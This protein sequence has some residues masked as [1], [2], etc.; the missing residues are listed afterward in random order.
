MDYAKSLRYLGALT[1]YEKFSDY[2]YRRS[3]NLRRINNFLALLG[4]PQ[5]KYPSVTVA[6]TKGKG[7]TVSML[8]SVTHAAGIKSGV[9]ISP[10][11]VSVTERIRIDGQSIPEKDFALMVSIVKSVIEKNRFQGLTFF[12]AVTAAA[13]LYFAKK[14]VG[15]AILEVGLGGRLDAVNT[16]G[17]QVVAIMPISYDHTGLLGASLKEIAA[18]KG[19]IIHKNSYVTVA[20]Q[21][22][23]AFDAINR[24]AIK[25]RSK[26]FAI[27]KDI[28][29]TNAR[30]SL[31]GTYFDI[32]TMS[33]HYRDLYTPLI[34]YH[35]AVNAGVAVS[36]SEN[37]N[38]AYG[39]SIGKSH[40]R[41]G[42]RQANF[43]GRFQIF[44]CEPYIVLDGAQNQASAKALKNTLD[45]V[46][47]KRH[48]CFII[49]VSSDKDCR[50][51]IRQLS[52]LSS[53]IIFTQADSTRAMPAEE[54]IRRAGG[55]S[56]DCFLC[57]DI[58]DSILFARSITPKDGVIVVTGSLFLVGEALSIL[59]CKC[60]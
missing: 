10:H 45:K 54:L 2:N 7:S 15:I 11:L 38:N 47:N 57:R 39:L 5:K 22:R 8:G 23:Q 17:S 1:N 53:Q 41:K 33:G 21:A 55:L 59:R 20:P 25:T 37:I 30:T 51:I 24:I 19:G 52:A 46:F 50:F 49:G 4:N 3:Y 26:L 16:A 60:V 31:R 56:A 29:I 12:E 36:L 9:F 13:F 6:G 40:I 35:Q 28:K 44:P 48:I 27:D 43:D 34:G 14:K 32:K 42:L 58:R 18:E